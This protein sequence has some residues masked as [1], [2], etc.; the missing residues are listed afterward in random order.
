MK[1]KVLGI[2]FSTVL[3]AALVT[4]CSA[5]KEEAPK[6]NGEATEGEA[7]ADDTTADGE[8]VVLKIGAC[9]TPHG[10]ILTSLKESLA[11]EG[12]D[13]QVV[14]FT[15]YVQPNLALDDGSLDANYF[16]H[17]PYLDDFNEKNGTKLVS[18]GTVHYE[19]MGIYPGKTKDLATLPDGAKVSVPNDP[20]NEARALLLLEANGLIKVNPDAGLAATKL[21]IIEN[22]KKLE[23]IEIEAAQLARAIGDV[24][25]AVI[26]GNYAIQAG[27]DVSKDALSKEEKDSLAAETYAN[28]VAVREGDEQRPEIVKLVEALQSQEVKDYI[29]NN[30]QGAVESMAK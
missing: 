5:P 10:E 23:I 27:M 18:V 25:I 11:A 14:E 21:D 8:K 9:P 1:K 12:I 6:E 20:T 17:L 19:P 4:G 16:Q 15:D 28:I 2:V 26:N 13:L 30:Y 3:A 7:P 24:D 29:T 22:P